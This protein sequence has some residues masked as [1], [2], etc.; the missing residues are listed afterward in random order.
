MRNASRI[1]SESADV[2]RAEESVEQVDARIADL[3]RELETT[4]ASLDTRLDAQNL[5]LRELAIAPRKTDIAVGK[6]LLL[7]TPWRVGADGFPASA[8]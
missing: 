7:W 6:V 5:A 1:G 8:A 2:D 3:N 4:I